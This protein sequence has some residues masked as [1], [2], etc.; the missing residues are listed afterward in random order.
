MK[1]EPKYKDGRVI[2]LHKDGTVSYYDGNQWARREA[3]NISDQDHSFLGS[4]DSA[5]ICRHAQERGQEC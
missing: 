1:N 4:K 2:T 5:K 3:A